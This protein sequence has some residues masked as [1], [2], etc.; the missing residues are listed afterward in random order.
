MQNTRETHP[1]SSTDPQAHHPSG[2]RCNPISPDLQAPATTPETP[3]SPTT[4]RPV[5]PPLAKNKAKLKGTSGQVRRQAK[6]FVD[7]T[8]DAAGTPKRVLTDSVARA[9]EHAEEVVCEIAEVGEEAGERI[10]ELGTKLADKTT[11]KAHHIA[12]GII[13][14]TDAGVKTCKDM[15]YLGKRLH[16]KAVVHYRRVEGMFH[17][18]MGATRY[19]FEAGGRMYAVHRKYEKAALVQGSLRGGQCS[20]MG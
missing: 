20:R 6:L 16:G 12:D 13:D 3:W 4:S 11:E 1:V 7:A 5:K 19:G 9:T 18:V 14:L 15:S 17:A 8:T 2:L 10:H